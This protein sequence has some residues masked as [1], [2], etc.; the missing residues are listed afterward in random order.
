MWGPPVL[1]NRTNLGLVL[2]E[3]VHKKGCFLKISIVDIE[4]HID[5]LFIQLDQNETANCY[6]L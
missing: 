4:I 3:Y 1:P 5:D 2:N 6:H